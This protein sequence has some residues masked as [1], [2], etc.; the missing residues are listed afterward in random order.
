MKKY[1]SN[2]GKPTT[3]KAFDELGRAYLA[4]ARTEP[5]Y[6]SAMFEA[7]IAP[8]TSAELS[9]AGDRAFATMMKMGKPDIA[10]LKAAFEGRR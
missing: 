5:A 3:R 9:A 2:G 6:Y 8:N 10:V 1:R 4:F 7:G